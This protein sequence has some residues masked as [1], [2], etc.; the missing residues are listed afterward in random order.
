MMLKIS[1]LYSKPYQI[2]LYGISK[3]L[4][5]GDHDGGGQEDGGGP[6]VE[7]A[8]C[9]VVNTWLSFSQEKFPGP[10]CSC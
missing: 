9:P 1:L 4:V 2:T 8:E 10:T 3:E 7:Q 6:L 5:G